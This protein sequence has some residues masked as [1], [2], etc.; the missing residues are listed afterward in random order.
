MNWGGGRNKEGEGEEGEENES[1]KSL[2]TNN[3]RHNFKFIEISGDRMSERI[4]IAI[5]SAVG[6]I[7]ELVG[8]DYLC[9]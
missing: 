3:C 6:H 7:P 5:L 1:L 8:E 2:G 4:L 9:C